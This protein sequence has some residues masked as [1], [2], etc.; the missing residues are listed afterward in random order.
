MPVI[1]KYNMYDRFSVVELTESV[2]KPLIK[3][4]YD[5]LY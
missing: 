1:V 4:T 2:D 3:S 5:D